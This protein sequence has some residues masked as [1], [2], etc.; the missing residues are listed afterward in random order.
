MLS[1][2]PRYRSLS[3]MPTYRCTAECLH[4]GTL[5]SPREKT[6]LPIEHI[7]K[8]IDQAA[9]N[10][11]KVVIFTGGEATLADRNLILRN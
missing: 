3:I 9:D 6:W 5:S 7:L 4:C 1:R 2:I 10:D 11:Y 8:A